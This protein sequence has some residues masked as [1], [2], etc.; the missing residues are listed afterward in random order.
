VLYR[1]GQTTIK[2]AT[3]KTGEIVTK[4]LDDVLNQNSGFKILIIISNIPNGEKI[5]KEKLPEDLTCDDLIH[6]KFAPISSV[7]VERSFS[8]YK[9]ILTDRRK[10]FLFENLKKVL[11]IQCTSD[12]IGKKIIL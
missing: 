7:D 5:S 12:D 2:Q 10:R 9:H 11:I 8:K 6:Y 4:K 1:K 3:G